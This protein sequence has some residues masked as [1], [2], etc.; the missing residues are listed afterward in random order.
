MAEPL[1]TIVEAVKSRNYIMS[2][3]YWE[4]VAWD[5]T[6]P[7]PPATLASIGNNE[8]EIIENY[9]SDSRGASCL[10]LGVNGESRQIHTV[11]GYGCQP[12]R[13]V[14]AYH[15][16]DDVWINGRTRR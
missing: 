16:T 8:P 3:H 14:T 6:R 12:I 10:I 2:L 1:D 7:L 13:I 4:K 15:P 9:S 5:A 11:V